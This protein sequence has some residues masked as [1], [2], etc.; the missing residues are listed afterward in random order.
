MSPGQRVAAT[1]RRQAGLARALW[2]AVRGRT[3]VDPGD[4]A[5]P[6][7]GID[8]AVLW[9]ITAVG[10][11]ETVIVHVVVSWPPLRWSLFVLSVFGL[12][13]LVAFDRT[14]RQQPHVVRG[15]E[16]VLRFGHFRSA[17]IPLDHLVSVRKHVRNDHE[18]TLELGGTGLALSFMG[19]TNVELRFSP[20]VV[21]RTDGRSH[22]V[23]QVSFSVHDPAGAV[24]SL[25]T[26]MTSAER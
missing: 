3:A 23:E 17:Q 7:N 25:R 1:A 20:A 16:L 9:T 14:M 6:Y 18:K 22:T 21:V 2:W 19:G 8:Q 12:L 11:L 24:A 26:R 15:G 10:A 13:G 5:L 4:L